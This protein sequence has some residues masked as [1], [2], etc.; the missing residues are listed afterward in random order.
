[1][2]I[3][4]NAPLEAYHPDGRVVA[5]KVRQWL[6][7]T[8]VAITPALPSDEPDEW[9]VDHTDFN[10]DGT[11]YADA[12]WR[13]RNRFPARDPALVALERIKDIRLE[14]EAA[15]IDEGEAMAEICR[16]LAEL[17]PEPVDPLYDAL[18]AVVELGRYD[19][20]EQTDLLRAEL[21]KRGLEI[22]KVAA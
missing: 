18:F 7:E 5:V 22:V 3:D 1:M 4:W 14:F 2:A 21:A 10:T 13:I 8:K 6:D 20:R 16:V 9:S 11:H 19:T 12:K 15:D 17:E